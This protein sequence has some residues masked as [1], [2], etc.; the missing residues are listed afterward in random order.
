MGSR[1]QGDRANAVVA[2][3][4]QE[5]G[6]GQVTDLARFADA[7][8]PGHVGHDDVGGVLLDHLAKAEFADQAFADTKRDGR[9]ML[10]PRIGLHVVGRHDL[11]QPHDVVWLQGAGDLDGFR[12]VPA[13]MAFDADFHT[14]AHGAADVLHIRHAA[15]EVFVL[16]MVAD[17]THGPGSG[18]LTHRPTQ[19]HAKLVE[20]PNLH[21]LDALA[22]QLRG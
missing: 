14:V 4:G 15:L 3:D 6:L 11:F 20:G 10:E 18:P 8:A 17:W 19:R 12:Q 2:G 7:A 16:E 21:G 13:R 22:Q 1:P 9:L 5:V